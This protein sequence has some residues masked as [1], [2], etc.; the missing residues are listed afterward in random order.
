M[1]VNNSL[2]H[3]KDVSNGSVTIPEGFNTDFNRWIGWYSGEYIYIICRWHQSAST[4]DN[5]LQIQN[6]GFQKWSGINKTKF[7]KDSARQ[8]S[9]GE[10]KYTNEWKLHRQQCFERV[11]V[12]RALHLRQQRKHGRKR[13]DVIW[14]WF[15]PV[16]LC[17]SPMKAEL[18]WDAQFGEEWFRKSFR[19]GEQR[20]KENKSERHKNK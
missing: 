8:Q 20:S 11:I 12:R 2:P 4:W 6:D 5:R 16:P 13:A 3:G 1:I 17:L 18:E 14:R 9:W 7:D 19:Q 10:I 15:V